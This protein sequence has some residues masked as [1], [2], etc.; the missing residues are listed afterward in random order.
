M[1][2]LINALVSIAS[3]ILS[4]VA[5]LIGALVTLLTGG[6]QTIIGLA[7]QIIQAL[8]NGF[9]AGAVSIPQGGLTCNTP[10]TL[11]YYPCL[12][13]YVLDNTIWQGPVAYLIPIILGTAT[14]RLLMWAMEKIRGVFTA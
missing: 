6:L 5:T 3:A 10:G 4:L 8:I 11:L 7:V 14:I 9:N 13:F 12:G 2:A 1:I